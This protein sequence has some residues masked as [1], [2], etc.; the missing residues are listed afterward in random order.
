M[1]N[2]KDALLLLR[3]RFVGMKKMGR[4]VEAQLKGVLW[5]TIPGTGP[6]LRYVLMF[7]K[8]PEPVASLPGAVAAGAP[9]GFGASH[10]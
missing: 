5:W 10:A 4:Y 1:P 9:F 3:V 2:D 6:A 8:P 7:R